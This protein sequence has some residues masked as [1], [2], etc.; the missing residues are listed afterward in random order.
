MERKYIS[1]FTSGTYRL[2]KLDDVSYFEAWSH[3]VK[4]HCHDQI[5][6]NGNLDV[7][8][9]RQPLHLLCST[10]DPETFCQISRSYLISLDHVLGYDR[11]EVMMDDP[12][13]KSIIIGDKYRKAFWNEIRKRSLFGN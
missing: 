3:V 12:F 1:V 11:Y 4:V 10:L 2:V 6:V 5:D 9:V 8:Y 7:P 13:H